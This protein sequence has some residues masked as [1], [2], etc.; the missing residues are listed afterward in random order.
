MNE[1]M[2]PPM[3]FVSEN[4]AAHDDTVLPFEV[5]ALDIRGRTIQMGAALD[6]LL[7]RHAYPPAV[8]RIL[9]EAAVLTGL[10]GTALKFEG[11]FQL[12]TRTDGPI[13]LLVVDFEAPDR[14]RG[15]ARFDATRVEETVRHAR[16]DASLGS[17]LLGNGHLGLTLDQGAHMNQYQGI[18]ALEGQDLEEAAHQYFR[19]SEQIPTRIRLA[20]GEVMRA[21]AGTE[22]RKTHSWRGGGVLVQFLPSAPE[23]QRQPDFD[24][25]DAPEGVVMPE[26][27]ED[28][29]WT[30]A[31]SLVETVED[32]ELLDPSLSSERLLYR[33]FHERGVRVFDPVPVREACRCSEPRIREM[34]QG[35]SAEERSAMVADDGKIGVTCEFC[36][37]HY[38]FDPAEFAAPLDSGVTQSD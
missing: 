24:P 6:T 13:D 37:K 26:F 3:R 12:Q 19:Q 16:R 18:V 32:H 30:E 22:D 31:R 34:L 4:A 14:I 5:D 15:Y 29:A 11:R 17:Q 36:S 28:D 8:A 1:A 25:G 27:S 21:S 23:R 33:L 9:G 35:F 20:V 2:Q 10:L 7:E 38:G